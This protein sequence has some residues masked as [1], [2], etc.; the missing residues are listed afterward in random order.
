MKRLKDLNLSCSH[1]EDDMKKRHSLYQM[2]I[3]EEKKQKEK[4]AKERLSLLE[5]K[6]KVSVRVTCC[7]S[8]RPISPEFR[9]AK[10]RMV[11]F[12]TAGFS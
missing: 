4:K 9:T 8:D 10:E 12:L 5:E 6:K 11:L 3:E 2:R 1:R 7:I